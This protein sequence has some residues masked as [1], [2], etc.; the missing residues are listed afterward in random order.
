MN[1]SLEDQKLVAG[2]GAEVPKTLQTEAPLTE[3]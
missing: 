3:E 2:E 1:A